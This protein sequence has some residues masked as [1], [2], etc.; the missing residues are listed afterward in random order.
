MAVCAIVRKVRQ[1]LVVTVVEQD[2]WETN[3]KFLV[4]VNY[5]NIENSLVLSQTLV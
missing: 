2:T 4:S 1:E 3:V 5:F